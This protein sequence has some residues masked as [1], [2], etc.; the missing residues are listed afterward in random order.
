MWL[1]PEVRLAGAS[2]Q[3][4]VGRRRVR[5]R[6]EPELRRLRGDA[7]VLAVGLGFAPSRE[8]VAGQHPPLQHQLA[9]AAI[10]DAEMEPLFE[11][12]V[13]VVLQAQHRARL[14]DGR[15]VDVLVNNA[16]LQ[17]V[18]QLEEFPPEKWAQL[19]DVMLKGSA[20]MPR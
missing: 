2:P 4:P 13:F 17:H 9:P 20:A 15:H 10:G 14:M 16:G 18:A 11:F 3:M 19:I 8:L 5:L 1:E 7:R 6:G 12:A